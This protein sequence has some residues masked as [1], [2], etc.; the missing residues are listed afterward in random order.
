MLSALVA[1]R[2]RGVTLVV[3]P[4]DRE[5]FPHF[6][7]GSFVFDLFQELL[8]L[9]VFIFLVGLETEAARIRCLVFQLGRLLLWLSQ[10]T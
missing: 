1:L 5:I 2:G 8:I 9:V 10:L 7:L 6:Q 4:V 3:G